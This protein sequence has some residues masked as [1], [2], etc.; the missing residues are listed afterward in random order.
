VKRGLE[1]SEENLAL[2]IIA[3]VGPGGTFMTNKHTVKWMRSAALMTRL[4]DRE[5]REVWRNKGALDTHKRALQ[6]AR[7]ILC[8]PNPAIFTPEIEERIRM[9]FKTLVPGNATAPQGW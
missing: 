7:D 4:A 3:Q 5:P 2:D 9:Q 8:Q 6:R 1:F